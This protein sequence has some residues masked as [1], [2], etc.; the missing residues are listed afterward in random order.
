M[1]LI[2]CFLTRTVKILELHPSVGNKGSITWCIRGLIRLQVKP[3][4][5]PETGNRLFPT[6]YDCLLYFSWRQQTGTVL[7]SRENMK[8]K[9][10]IGL[11]NKNSIC[12]NIKKSS[13]H[14]INEDMIWLVHLTK[15]Q[16]KQRYC[17]V[18]LWMFPGPQTLLLH[19]YPN[20]KVCQCVVYN[21]YCI[22]CG[23]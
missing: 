19:F 17:L 10:V 11:W 15:K 12:T 4:S 8:Q 5:P 3:V 21:T 23:V 6:T 22:Y 13:L 20:I 14:F 2:W 16:S 18:F 1:Q 9:H 7:I